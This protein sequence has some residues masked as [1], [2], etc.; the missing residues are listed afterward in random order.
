MVCA[1]TSSGL[2][3][4]QQKV[5]AS[6]NYEGR[7][8]CRYSTVVTNKSAKTLKDL[9]VSIAKL[10]GPLWGLTRNKDSFGFPAWI[11]SLSAGKSLEFVYIHAASPADISISTY[12]LV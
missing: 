4:I 10:C 8:Y 2:I 1:A 9:Q 6:W 3:T 5:T 7:T 11:N 12:T